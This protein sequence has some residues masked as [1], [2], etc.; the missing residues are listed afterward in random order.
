MNGRKVRWAQIAGLSLLAASACGRGA[1]AARVPDSARTPVRLVNVVAASSDDTISATGTLGAREDIALSFKVGGIVSEVLVD[2]GATVVRGQ[3]LAA[4]D[5]REIDAMLSKATAAAAK[6]QRD[7]ARAERL[8]RDSVATLAQVQDAQTGREAA[9]AD[10]R[11]AKVNHEGSVIV[12][13]T[14]GMVLRRFA[15]AGQQMSPGVPIL[16]LASTRRGQVLRAGLPDRDAVRVRVGAAVQVTFD[17]V[18]GKTYRGRI[19]QRAAFADP[20]TGTFS[21]EATIEGAEQLPAGLIGRISIRVAPSTPRS[22]GGETVVPAEALVEGNAGEG[23]VYALDAAGVHAR[24]LRVTLVGVD[25]DWVRVRGLAG[26]R[27]VVGAG[28]AWLSDGQLVEIVR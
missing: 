17:A 23:T 24:K 10:L 7:A 15:N 2:E 28:S 11:A 25:G 18:P 27:Q 4:L 1:N 20:R 22:A 8:Y 14:A 16:V 21:I 13:P 5:T 9:E 19:S 12:A 3:R 26:V 6:A